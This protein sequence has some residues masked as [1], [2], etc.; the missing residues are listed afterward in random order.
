MLFH[1]PSKLALK[2]AISVGATIAC[3]VLVFGCAIFLQARWDEQK[4]E[5]SLSVLSTYIRSSTTNGARLRTEIGRSGRGMKPKLFT[6]DFVPG[7]YEH[8]AL[9]IDW[10]AWDVNEVAGFEIEFRDGEIVRVIFPTIVRTELLR[11]DHNGVFFEV[12]IDVDEFIE[13][14]D[15]SKLIG[16][17]VRLIDVNG[18]LCPDTLRVR[19]IPIN[20]W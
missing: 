7:Y 18:K 5:R 6:V 9:A 12:D 10:I 2:I 19:R 8:G 17:G 11:R 13:P 1:F 14:E 3:F 4:R 16:S 15:R 20:G